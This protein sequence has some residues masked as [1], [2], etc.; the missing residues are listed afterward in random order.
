MNNYKSIVQAEYLKLKYRVPSFIQDK[1]LFL[2]GFVCHILRYIVL[3][4]WL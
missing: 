4:S 3:Y 2:L 1:N